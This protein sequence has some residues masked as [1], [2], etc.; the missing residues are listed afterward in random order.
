MRT[1]MRASENVGVGGGPTG[2]ITVFCGPGP[3]VCSLP[4]S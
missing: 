1:A 3:P 2:R 4:T